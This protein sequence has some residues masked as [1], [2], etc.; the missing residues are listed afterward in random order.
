MRPRLT[1][2]A[3]L[4]LA[5]LAAPT[6]AR[7][8]RPDLVN[9][10]IDRLVTNLEAV[11]KKEPKN[12]AARLNVARAHGMAYA[13]KADSAQVWRNKEERG[14]WFGFTPKLA[15]FEV[16]KTDDRK[17]LAEAQAHL[18]KAKA[19]FDE[20]L[21]L[22]ENNLSALLGRAWV[23]EQ[24]GE[25]KEAVAAYRATIKKAW[26][27]EKEAQVGGLGGRFYTAEAAEYLV[28]LLDA[29]ADKKEI[30][31]LKER[32]EKLR[33]LPR[34]VT[35]IAVPLRGG[36]GAA[37]LIDARAR[38][39]FDADGSGL[40]RRWTWVAPGKAGW[41]VYDPRAT[42]RVTSGLQLFGSVTFWMFWEDGYQA[43]SA[44]DDNGDGVLT[45]RELA[46]LAIW[47]DANGDGVCDPGEVRPLAEYGIVS[48]SCRADR[49]AVPPGCAAWAR[50]GVTFRDGTTRPTFDVV[51]QRQK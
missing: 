35:P 12:V 25:K 37:D 43:L 16:K 20:A 46:G 49:S 10:P 30:A 19:W 45:G 31:E 40:K 5:C 28:P 42:G 17:K 29:E 13:S 39:A 15:P 24:S 4:L 32:S 34:P 38:V 50:A 48:L 33:K 51:L 7:F 3:L 21:K 41:L 44:L 23:L 9:V 1:C 11:A 6:A 47:H 27:K 2:A 36:L 26:E 8:L 22:D 18:R 14:V